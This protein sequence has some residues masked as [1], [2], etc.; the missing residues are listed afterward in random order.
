MPGRSKLLITVFYFTF[1][2]SLATNICEM[3]IFGLS[4]CQPDTTF[5]V[6]FNFSG[7][8]VLKILTLSLVNLELIKSTPYVPV[9]P[10]LYPFTIFGFFPLL[11]WP[12]NSYDYSACHKRNLIFSI[13]YAENCSNALGVMALVFLIWRAFKLIGYWMRSRMLLINAPRCN[14]FFTLL[15]FLFVLVFHVQTILLGLGQAHYWVANLFLEYFIYYFMLGFLVY[16]GV[17]KYK[18]KEDQVLANYKE[19]PPIT[20]NEPALL[21]NKVSQSA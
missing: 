15:R 14:S 8:V 11:Q 3:V 16:Y 20:D 6:Y 5:W 7:M 1:M 17:M 12:Q 18:K 9:A 10:F 4:S 13:S 2:A 19:R 21:D